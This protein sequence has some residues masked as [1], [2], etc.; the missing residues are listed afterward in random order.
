MK[1]L[2]CRPY[3][4]DM[5][6]MGHIKTE[7]LPLRR[8]IGDAR[9]AAGGELMMLGY[10]ELP[11]RSLRPQSGTVVH[12]LSIMTNI[13]DALFERN[14]RLGASL[15]WE[16]LFHEPALQQYWSYFQAF[17]APYGRKDAVFAQF[18]QYVQAGY[19][20]HVANL[21][22]GLNLSYE[23]VLRQVA[24]DSADHIRLMM[25][26]IVLFNAYP[27]EPQIQTRYYSLGILMNH[28]DDLADLEHEMANRA[29][30]LMLA[31]LPSPM[32]QSAF[33][34]LSEPARSETSDGVWPALPK[35][36]AR[37]WEEWLG[38]GWG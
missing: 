28:A 21:K 19:V 35:P 7:K 6:E 27:L 23:E 29:P 22:R 10:S 9:G 32:R 15:D 8:K 24:Y 2:L 30:N 11:R 3:G 5:P 13:F 31:L 16:V 34:I 38:I 36:L 14:L 20:Q 37:R 26:L 33:M 17:L 4:R 1:H 25:D 18:E 12:L